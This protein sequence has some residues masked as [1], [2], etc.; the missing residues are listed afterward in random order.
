MPCRSLSLPALASLAATLAASEPLTTDNLPLGELERPLILRTYVP[1]PGIDDAVFAN[2]HRGLP[3]PEY[4]ASQGRDVDGEVATDDGIPAA[5]AVNH[6][7]ALSY[8][9]DTTECRLLFAWQGG[10]LDMFP[11]WGDPALGQRRRRDYVPRLVGTVFHQ[12]TGAHPLQLDGRPLAA[13]GAPRFIGYDLDTSGI[14]TFLFEAGG[15]RVR[16]RVD[17]DLDNPLAL[18]MTIHC[19]DGTLGWRAADDTTVKATANG[20]LQLHIRGRELSTH[21]GFD[22][23]FK[24]AAASLEAGRQLYAAY[25]CAACHSSDGSRGHGP[26]FSGLAGSRRAIEG[27]DEP[28]LADANYLK[29]SILNPNAKTAAGFPPNYMPPYPLKPVEVESLVLFIQSLAAP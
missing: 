13:H 5:I 20:T 18:K 9:F 23:D 26:T 21:D 25:G 28:V 8:A 1:D 11:Y 29:E 19:N 7:P 17:P 24:I 15:K 16:Q 12:A 6:G 4:S 22:R 2:H 3:T 27:A 14:P 10:F